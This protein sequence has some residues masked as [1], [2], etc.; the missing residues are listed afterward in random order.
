[1]S[2][3]FA[4]KTL[5]LLGVSM[6]WRELCL[7]HMGS[8]RFQGPQNHGSGRPHVVEQ[9]LAAEKHTEKVGSCGRR[10]RPPSPV[11]NSSEDPECI[12]VTRLHNVEVADV[13]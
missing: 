2:T 9:G 8:I 5:T 13:T 4:G 1:M 3:V 12:A 7:A 6:A 10:Q 11:N